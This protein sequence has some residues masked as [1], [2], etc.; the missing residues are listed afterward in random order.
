MTS[1]T[2]LGFL[3]G[4]PGLRRRRAVPLEGLAA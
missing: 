2:T 4:G 1:F 3:V